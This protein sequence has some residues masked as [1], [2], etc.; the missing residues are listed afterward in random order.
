MVDSLPTPRPVSSNAPLRPWMPCAALMGA[1]CAAL[2][3]ATW[4]DGSSADPPPLVAAVDPNVA[5]WWELAALP[6][7]GEAKA[8]AVVAYREEAAAG[9]DTAACVFR[10]PTDLDAV[11]GV[12]PTIV[13]RLAPHLRFDH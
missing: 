6:G 3:V 2:L 4:W 10:K 1:L 8:R 9:G 11:P 13:Q 5:P 12:G 7:L